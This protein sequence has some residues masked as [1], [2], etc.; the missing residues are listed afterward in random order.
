MPLAGSGE[1]EEGG[2]DTNNDNDEKGFPL[3]WVL[4]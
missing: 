1:E 4:T 2:D 3:F